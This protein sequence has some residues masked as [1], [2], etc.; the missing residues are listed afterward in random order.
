MKPPK[1]PKEPKDF[2]LN[3]LMQKYPHSIEGTEQ[4]YY[5]KGAYDLISKVSQGID[6]RLKRDQK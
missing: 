1:E 5:I 6:F 3:E 4:R 2:N